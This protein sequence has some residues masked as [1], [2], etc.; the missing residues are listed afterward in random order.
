MQEVRL[1][2]A[3][4]KRLFSVRRHDAIMMVRKAPTVERVGHGYARGVAARGAVS[5]ASRCQGIYRPDLRPFWSA[6]AKQQIIDA[7]IA[8]ARRVE[9]VNPR[10][11]LRAARASAVMSYHLSAAT[12]ALRQSFGHP[13][14]SVGVEVSRVR[15]SCRCATRS[16]ARRGARASLGP[17][18]NGELAHWAP[19]SA[20][21][22]AITNL[23]ARLWR[24][25]P[26]SVAQRGISFG[27]KV[28]NLPDR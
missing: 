2:S 25:L 21:D 1:G 14:E 15:D 27:Q 16:L 3:G 13:G 24:C 19:L 20:H 23:G 28:S 9:A 18:F 10:G 12:R 6:S 17:A 26:S 11:L 8:I 4:S 22:E 7:T 5:A